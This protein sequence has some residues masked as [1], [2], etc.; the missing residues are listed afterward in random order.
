MSK[1]DILSLSKEELAARIELLGE[2]R[3]RAGQ[4]YK[5]LHVKKVK[6]FSQMT[7]LSEKLRQSLDEEFFIYKAEIVN[8]LVSSLDGTVKYLF[9]LQDGRVVEAV[10]MRYRHGNSLCISTQVGCKMGCSFCASTIAG[11]ERNLEPSEMLSQVYYADADTEGGVSSIVLMGIGEPLDNYDNV[12]K[13]LEILSS[14][15]GHNM[16]LR[17][18]SLS[19]C[20]IVPKIYELAEKNYGLTLSISLH[21]PNNDLRRRIMPV[22]NRYS[23]DELMKACRFYFEKT[24]RRIS[25]EYSLIDGVNDTPECAS[26]L[27][28]LLNGFLCHVNLIPVNEVAERSY[29]ASRKKSVENF[30]AI[31]EGGHINATVRRTLGADINAACGQLRRNYIKT[32][33]RTVNK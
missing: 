31:L 18:V 19:T 5:W 8:R 24:G 30:K 28:D 33:E 27:K 10:V 9:A 15:Q 21:A 26:E 32:K 6:E 11:F 29:R 4:I 17:H 1:T 23:I 7:D 16:S 25:F 13:F 22:A 20:G 12:T 3:F 2:K 14:E